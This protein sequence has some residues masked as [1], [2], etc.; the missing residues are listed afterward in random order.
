MQR[1][2][3]IQPDGSP[4]HTIEA[5]NAHIAPIAKLYGFPLEMK[6]SGDDVLLRGDIDKASCVLLYLCSQRRTPEIDWL[7][8]TVRWFQVSRVPFDWK[9]A[10]AKIRHT[11]RGKWWRKQRD[12][13]VNARKT[14][15]DPIEPDTWKEP[16][17]CFS[18]NTMLGRSELGGVVYGDRHS[19]G[20][21][22]MPAAV[23]SPGTKIPPHADDVD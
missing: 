1:W 7:L 18:E 8:D 20:V 11:K 21:R 12:K 4:D 6:L 13:Q 19:P 14:L 16:D 9:R 5:F 10:W 22:E 2:C 3:R 23:T 17:Q 15:I